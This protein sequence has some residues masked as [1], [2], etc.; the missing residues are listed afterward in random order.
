[1]GFDFDLVAVGGGPSGQKA[2]IQAAKLGRR[3]ALIECR[4]IG[5]VCVITGTI[6]SKTLREA[7]LHLTG[8]M[9]RGIYGQSYR[10]KEDIT[11]EDLRSRYESVIRR[12]T[13]VIRD[14]LQRNHVALIEGLAA[15]VDPHTLLVRTP[16]GAERRVSADQIIVAAGTR[17]AR[18]E[19]VAFDERTIFD[20]D[21][22]V[23]LERIPGSLV[24]VGGGVIG[25][26][27]ASFFAA[28]GTKVTVVD[29][30][31]RILDFCDDEITEGLQH[32]LRDLGV[33]FRL[34]EEV[35]AV[36]S[37][38]EGA[39]V[40][41]KSGKRVAAE[42][43]LYSAGRIGATDDLDLEKAGLAADDRGRISVDENFRTKVEHIHAVGDVIGFP[44]LAA[45]AMEQGRVAALDALGQ[46]HA[47]ATAL[48]PIGIYT[49]PEISFVGKT[50]AEL[51]EA[52]VPYEVGISR[53]RELARGAI[54]GE[55]H[56]LLKILVSQ[57][58]HKLLG[59]HVLGTSATEVVHIGQ[60]V[61]GNGG[62][63]EYL[64][65]AVFNYPTLA[66]AYKVAA[67]DAQNKLRAVGRF[68]V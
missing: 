23:G 52:S 34:G 7:V 58:D 46:E 32:H 64:V 40:R 10:V 66:E 57:E 26:E 38:E 53:Y 30:R 11:I 8:F 4:Q 18:P 56:G 37:L 22:L 21:G 27:Y 60:A 29:K 1:M 45:T 13:D 39:L 25:I 24:V 67:L 14:Q 15:F 61:M 51:T 17:P 5:G 41:L 54:L 31:R 19:S 65:D 42:A 6:P 49:I 12:E 62:T 59:V 63:L 44:S 2:A 28:L 43:V 36:E 47:A 68:A 50:E 48:L 9:Q 33:T 3:A 55:S 35:T 20:S 16:D